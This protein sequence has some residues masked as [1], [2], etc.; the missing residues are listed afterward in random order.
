MVYV[1]RRED[2]AVYIY[3]NTLHLNASQ[4][5]TLLPKAK[6]LAVKVADVITAT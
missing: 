4:Q 1:A 2:W 3:D 6:L 5:S